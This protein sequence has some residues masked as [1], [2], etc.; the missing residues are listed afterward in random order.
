LQTKELIKK[1]CTFTFFIYFKVC[2]W[3]IWKKYI[4]DGL[5]LFLLLLLLLGF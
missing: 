2:I 4:F 5:L 3:R 1:Y